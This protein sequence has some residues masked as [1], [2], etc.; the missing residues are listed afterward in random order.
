M[1]QLY[2]VRAITINLDHMSVLCNKD[3][4]TIYICTALLKNI[5]SYLGLRRERTWENVFKPN[6]IKNGKRH[7]S[8]TVLQI[9]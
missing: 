1:R 9:V 4:K 3:Q 8:S 6:P 5:H 7:V 2:E